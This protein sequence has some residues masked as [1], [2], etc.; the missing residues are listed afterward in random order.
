MTVHAADA[1]EQNQFLLTSTI[2]QICSKSGVMAP[3]S[4]VGS[5]F[6]AL[7]KTIG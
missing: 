3:D 1:T 4:L 7:S 6:A 5:S 2:S